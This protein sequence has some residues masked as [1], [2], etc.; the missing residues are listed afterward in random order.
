MRLYLNYSTNVWQQ[1][2]SDGSVHAPFTE[3][4]LLYS[5]D[6]PLTIASSRDVATKSELWS[7]EDVAA[8]RVSV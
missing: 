4:E 2:L 3:S 1:C 5:F 8:G 6:K 7:V